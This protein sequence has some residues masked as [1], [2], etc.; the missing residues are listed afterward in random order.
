M[1]EVD[2]LIQTATKCPLVEQVP[3]VTTILGLVGVSAV[4]TWPTAYNQLSTLDET[5]D[6]SEVRVHKQFSHAQSNPR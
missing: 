6:E 4:K 5:A 1:E 3:G 2:T